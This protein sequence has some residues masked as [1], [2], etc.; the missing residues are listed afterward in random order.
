MSHFDT[1]PACDRQTDGQRTDLL[2]LVQRSVQ[3]A[4]LTRCKTIGF[5]S[6]FPGHA[7]TGRR[8]LMSGICTCT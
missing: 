2:Q 6:N 3:Q 5:W 4:V 7:D 8:K 1:V